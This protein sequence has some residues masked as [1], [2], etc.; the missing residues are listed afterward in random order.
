L[1]AYIQRIER[2]GY[3]GLPEPSIQSVLDVDND[4]GGQVRVRW[5]PS[6]LDVNPAGVVDEYR[7]WREVSA[8]AANAGIERGATLLRGGEAIPEAAFGRR[9][10]RTSSLGTANFYWELVGTQPANGLSGYSKVTHTGGDS[11]SSGTAW[12]RFMVEARQTSNGYHWDSAPDSGYSVDDLAP[13]APSPFSG[14]YGGGSSSLS[15]GPSEAPDVAFYR[16]YRGGDP[17]FAPGPGSL[18][19]T[20]NGTSAIDNA[21]APYWYKVTAV[22]AHGNEGPAATTLPSGTVDVDTDLPSVLWLGPPSPNP[23]TGQ[24]GFRLALPAASTVTLVLFDSQG[25]RVR[26]LADR[27]FDAG[28]HEIRWDGRGASGQLLRSGVYHYR[29]EAGG[30]ERRGTLV[31]TR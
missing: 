28:R 10:Y 12:T 24:T 26:A 6:Y 1:D 25:R 29:L 8:S 5:A 9:T 14:T 22:D 18:V 20:V 19:A 21:G 2:F 27:T 13:P 11:T 15:W 23:S 3:L 16:L 17:G 7:L 31:L 4:Q 30:E